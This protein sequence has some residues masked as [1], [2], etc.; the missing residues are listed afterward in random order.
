MLFLYKTSIFNSVSF[1]WLFFLQTHAGQDLECLLSIILPSTVILLI[2]LLRRKSVIIVLRSLFLT[3][4]EKQKN[5]SENRNL[6]TTFVLQSYST[7]I[8][9]S[10]F[11]FFFRNFTQNYLGS[12]NT[13]VQCCLTWY[14]LALAK[15]PIQKHHS[16]S[17]LAVPPR[18][19]ITT[20]SIYISHCSS[21]KLVSS[22][23]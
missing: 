11:M 20:K 3:A 17:W 7:T 9:V 12:W 10:V 18:Q 8:C 21:A 5:Y 6:L 14:W 13:L 1:L 2:R 23:Y 4:K 15:Q 22:L 16:F 19:E